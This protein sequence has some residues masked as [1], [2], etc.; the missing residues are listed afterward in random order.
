M[1]RV[2]LG[3]S[4]DPDAL[5]SLLRQNLDFETDRLAEL[6]GMEQACIDADYDGTFALLTIR[7][8]LHLTNAAINWTQESI[9]ALEAHAARSAQ[10]SAR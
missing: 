3:Q 9:A 5:V 10:E 2:F 6:E 7:A 1:L 8:G 4:G